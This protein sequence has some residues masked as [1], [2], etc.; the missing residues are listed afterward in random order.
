VDERAV[1]AAAARIAASAHG[2]FMGTG[3]PCRM[4]PIVA[5]DELVSAVTAGSPPAEPE[6]APEPPVEPASSLGGRL[7]ETMLWPDPDARP[8]Y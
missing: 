8:R 6:P 1:R 5:L 2:L 4:V 3:E 7:A